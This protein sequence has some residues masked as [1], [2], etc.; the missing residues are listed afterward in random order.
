MH[1]AV[2]PLFRPV[3]PGLLSLLTFVVGCQDGQFSL[4]PGGPEED[5]W[6]I[7]VTTATGGDHKALA[8]TYADALR[9]VEGLRPNLVQVVSEGDQSKVYYGR[10]KRSYDVDTGATAYKPDYQPD[11]L[12][13]RSLLVGGQGGQPFALAMVE[14]LPV[15]SRYPEW[16]LTGQPGHW[17]LNVAVFYNEGEMSS[18]RYAAEEYAA[19]LRRQGEE[20]YFHHGAV[21]SSVTIGLFPEHSLKLQE[22]RNPVT[23][24][25]DAVNE[26]V[27]PRLAALQNKHPYNREN[28]RVIYQIRRN[29][30]GEVV[31]R[32]P[33]PSFVV[34]VPQPA[35]AG[36]F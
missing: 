3:T 9:R 5:V 21:N 25:M 20:A 16:N 2:R 13:I 1:L 10:Y 35:P 12:R 30:A 6:A 11:L 18:R 27:D 36:G 4:R 17:S 34:A 19:E 29:S 22:R 14:P 33:N 7:L 8:E 24:V 15:P 28:G 26:I 32:I 23:G 31:D